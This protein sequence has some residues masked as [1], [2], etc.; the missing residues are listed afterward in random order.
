MAGVP[1]GQRDQMSD[2]NQAGR[3]VTG[4]RRAL[5]MAL[6][7]M[8]VFALLAMGSGPG[9]AQGADYESALF[10]LHRGFLVGWFGEPGGPRYIVHAGADGRGTLAVETTPGGDWCGAD[11]RVR[12]RPSHRPGAVARDAVQ[13]GSTAVG[14]VGG[15]LDILLLY[16]GGV[17]AYWRP[18]GGLGVGARHLEDT[19]NVVFRNGAIR[20]EAKLIPAP[21]TPE[22][23][24]RPASRGQHR[25]SFGD[26][27]WVYEYESSAEVDGLRGRHSADIVYFLI[28][29]GIEGFYSGAAELMDELTPRPRF[30]WSYPGPLLVAHEIGHTLGGNHEPA[31][32]GADFPEFVDGQVR[33]YAFGH[34]DLSS[35][36]ASGCPHTVMSLGVEANEAGFL[37][38]RAPFYSSIRHRP[39]GWTIGVTG[40]REVERV[41]HETVPI[42]VRN[43]EAPY[44]SERYPH[45][46]EATWT[47]RDRVRVTWREP[48][49]AD[50]LEPWNPLAVRFSLEGGGNSVFRIAGG[51]S[52]DAPD[53]VTP[54]VADGALVGAEIGGLR[55]AGAYVISALGPWRLDA[56]D[57][58]VRPLASDPFRLSP[59]RAASGAPSAPRRVAAQAIG[60]HSAHLGWRSETPSGGGFEIWYREWSDEAPGQVWRRYPEPIP[61]AARS[62]VIGGLAA[63]NEVEIVASHQNREGHWL[64]LDGEKTAVGR[65]SFVVVAYSE[66][67]WRASETFDFEFM[68]GPLPAPA[69]PGEIPVCAGRESGLVLDGYLVAVCAET[70]EGERRRAWNYGLDSERSGLLYFFDR[71]NVELLVKILDGCAINGH[72]WVFVAPVTTLAFRLTI[73]ETGPFRESRYYRNGYRRWLYDAGRR[74]QDEIHASAGR[75]IGDAFGTYP[76]VGNPRGRAG[77]TVSDTTAFPCTPAEIAAARA[78]AA[79][80]GAGGGLAPAH[81]PPAKPHAAL[82][83]GSRSDCEP[84]AAALTLGGGFEVSMC[85]ETYR[86]ERGAAVGRELDSER[87][88][89][90]YFF[91]RDNVEVLVKVLDGCAV[92]GHWWVFVAPLTDLAFNLRVGSPGGRRWTHGN[93]LGHMAESTSELAAFPCATV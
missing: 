58:W 54:I 29:T 9:R 5:R 50:W 63:Q 34:T 83:A 67:G 15:T 84:G 77:R 93:P 57:R 30:G 2:R 41:L 69:A 33:P 11:T 61:A 65:Y 39:H 20:Q 88:G 40:E 17:E 38:V 1:P 31:D 21:W 86:G 89:L 3:D 19:L 12:R 79:G 56:A 10:T 16:E 18:I 70:P 6:V 22:T 60:R 49:D 90:L 51:R 81:L 47:G 52:D 44:P 35:C 28:G 26:S 55:P 73:T 75:L 78:E 48:F 85:Y 23:L 74:R 25:R 46:V 76:L 42:S 71:D 64:D 4:G 53:N 91:D 59:P 27:S 45:R 66:R 72:R 43:S 8:A 13:A 62:T 87:S 92:N 7:A 24:T 14:S 37:A 80:T 82:R 32:F 36:S 68:P